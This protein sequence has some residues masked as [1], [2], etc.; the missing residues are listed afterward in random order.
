M[1]ESATYH[2]IHELSIRDKLLAPQIAAELSIDERTVRFWLD[3][4]SYRPRQGIKRESKL[5]GF[6][7]DIARWLEQH[8]LSAVQV[9]RRLRE[10]GYTGGY[11]ILK[12][13]I[14]Q[15]RPA[16]IQP[17]LTLGFAPGECAQVDWGNAGS[18]AVGNTR[19]RLSFF[20]M[21]L[22]YSRRLYVEFTLSEAMDQFL[23]C[24]QN[25]FR[26]FQGVPG[27]VMLDNLK[28][29]V[30]SHPYG[31]RAA[32]HPR[33]EDFAKHYGFEP[34]ACGVRKPN[35][36]GRVENAV[37]YVK[38]SFLAGL[39]L[40]SLSAVQAAAE[41]WRDEVA[42]RRVHATTRQTPDERFKEETLRPLPAAGVYDVGVPRETMANCQFRVVFDTNRYSVPSKYAGNR[43]TLRVYPERL[44]IYHHE[45]LIASPVRSYERYQ[46]VLDPEHE[47]ELVQQRRGARDQ[48][49][50]QHYLQLGPKAEA[51]FL[52]MQERRPNARMHLRKIV[53]L[54][55]IYG[56]D[57]VR[58]ALDDAFELQTFSSEYIAN[59][60]E[61]R[62]RFRPQEPGVLHVPRAGDMLELDLPPADL[63]V[64]EGG[65]K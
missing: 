24:H 29:A 48:A 62:Q 11:S 2:R 7:K 57:A 37:G 1:I 23:A 6:R 47:R 31:Q 51:F 20:V 44:A 61:Q 50:W 42:N 34:R 40:P 32:Y 12:D 59:I 10:A 8:P 14:R 53:G 55:E 19:R 5:D 58:R 63:S 21:V 49:T 13:Y 33:Y 43:V 28:T 26:F 4:E 41:R 27:T 16:R 36:K 15:I 65:E 64:Y 9:L 17:H 54:S 52:Q 30:L 45:I 35:E 39:E 25:A 22:C 18:L 46:D 60:L 56:V 38:K 3:Q